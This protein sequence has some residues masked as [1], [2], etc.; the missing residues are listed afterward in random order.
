MR[1]KVESLG[2]GH[3]GK[4]KGGGL[5]K[6]SKQISCLSQGIRQVHPTKFAWAAGQGIRQV[7]PTK[8]A[9]A[10]EMLSRIMQFLL[11]SST[12][13]AWAAGMLSRIMQF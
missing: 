11:F 8:F 4:A 7:H 3:A 12:K 6:I 9:W 5:A 13:F 2:T 1:G 10:A